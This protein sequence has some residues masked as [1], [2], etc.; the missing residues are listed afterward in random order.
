MADMRRMTDRDIRNE[1]RRLA[2]ALDH[3]EWEGG[4]DPREGTIERWNALD[5]EQKRR[6]L[7]MRGK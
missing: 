1:K 2:Y 4:G 5:A 7:L 3:G 6:R